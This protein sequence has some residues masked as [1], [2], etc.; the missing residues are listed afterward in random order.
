VRTD[1]HLYAPILDNIHALEPDLRRCRDA[2]L[3]AQ[4]EAL[5]GLGRDVARVSLFAIAREA[6][7]RTL[8]LRPFDVQLLA[9]LALDDGHIVEMRTGEGKTLAAVLPAALNA[10]SGLGVHV[11]TFND[12]LARRDANWMRPVYEALGVSVSF[13]QEGM[14]PAERRRAYRADVTYVTAKE[15]GFDLLRDSL[16]MNRRDLVHRPFH[17]ALVDEADS[18]L[19]DEA[20]SPLVIAGNVDDE[21]VSLSELARHVAALAPGLDFDTDEYE[22]DVELTEAGLERLEAALGCGSLHDEKN[23]ELL[24]QINCALHA[25]V[26]LRNDVDYIVRDGR[27]QLVDELTGRIVHDRHWPD[28]LQAALEAKEG[29]QQ[30]PNG[31]VLGSITLQHFLGG[32]PRLCGMTGTAQD[33]A[34]ELA[35]TYD[36][37]VVVIPTNRPMIRQDHPDVVFTHRQAKEQ[38]LVEEIRRSHEASRPVLV[39]TLTIEESERLAARLREAGVACEVLNARHDADEARI[40]AHAGAARAV[41]I[42]TNMAG[43]GTDIRLGGPDEIDRDL[44]VRAGGLYVIGTNRHET[45]RVDLQLRGR[46]GRQGDPGAS[47]FFISLEDDLLVRYGIRDLIPARLMPAR[48]EA[49]VN[50]PIV[51]REIARAQR[52]VDGQNR[53]IRNT[54]QRYSMVVEGQRKRTMAER[55]AVLTSEELSDRDRSLRLLC[56]DRTWRTHLAHCADV[57]E[58]IHLVSLGGMDPLRRFTE[59]AGAAYRRFDEQVEAATTAAKSESIEIRGPSTT[60]TYLVND[61]P[62]RNQILTR[63]VGDGRN[64]LTLSAALVSAPLLVLWILADRFAKRRGTRR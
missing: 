28:G 62:F 60:W 43:R 23:Y 54:L 39:G 53:E 63:L 17:F 4:V 3:R 7:R 31:R 20:R 19:I 55:V 45:R 26:L 46:A 2:E 34:E 44:V 58:G 21:R 36:L 57:R 41:T 10:L 33:A 12:Y 56:I 22:R 49:P 50:H 8:R 52:I 38:A 9:A 47:R 11:L 5:R 64:T 32:Y 29:L 30:Q 27:I 37:D 18:I 40:I 15:A 48:T 6:A 59:E 24:T 42:S 13:V 35:H 16:A 51:R 1:L 61:D 14:T 25:R